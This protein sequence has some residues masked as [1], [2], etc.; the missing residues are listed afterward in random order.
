MQVEFEGM[1]VRVTFLCEQGKDICNGKQQLGCEST[2]FF[3]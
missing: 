3:G 2:T 1:V